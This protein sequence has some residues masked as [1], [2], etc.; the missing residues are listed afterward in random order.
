[1]KKSRQ[2]LILIAVYVLALGIRIYWFSQKEGLHVDEGL[3]IAIA[4]Y[5]DF[6]VTSN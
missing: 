2:A 3:T 5:N 6:M 4:C 1:M